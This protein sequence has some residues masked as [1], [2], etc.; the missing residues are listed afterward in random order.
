[1]HPIES[2]WTGGVVHGGFAFRPRWHDTTPQ[3]LLGRRFANRDQSDG[4]AALSM[5]AH[6]PS[7]ARHISFKLAQYFVADQPPPELVSAMTGVF[8]ATGGDIKAVVHTMLTSKQFRDAS[9]FGHKFK[10]PYQ[11]VV[12]VAR[13]SE[14]DPQNAAPLAEEMRALGQPLYGCL[15]PDGYACTESAW[16]DSDAMVRRISFA[17][18]FGTG[19]YMRHYLARETYTANNKNVPLPPQGGTGPLDSDRLMNAV[20]AELSSKTKAAVARAAKNLRAGVILG[21]PDFMRC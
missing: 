2:G 13:V 11:Y 15:T 7:T 21:S 16:L 14:L 5:L 1:V 12:S 20:G 4:E 19:A 10:T 8:Q 3:T 17:V 9:N 18:K 6:H